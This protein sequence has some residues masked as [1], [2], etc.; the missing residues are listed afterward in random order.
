MRNVYTRP[1]KQRLGLWARQT[2]YKWLHE[3]ISVIH[4]EKTNH[5]K[6]QTKWENL[7]Y[8]FQTL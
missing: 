5:L 8:P 3:L 2:T 4:K 1:F 6:S 7:E